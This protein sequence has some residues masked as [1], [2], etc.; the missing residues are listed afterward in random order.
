MDLDRFLERCR[1][2]QWAVADV[3][4]D[5]TPPDLPREQE[6]RVVQLFTD[7]VGV[8]RLAGALFQE[9]ARRT[10]DPVLK[11]VFE[12]FVK[13]EVR[14][15][16]VAQMLADHY[17]VH[18]YRL[19]AMNPHL[20][21]FAPHFV[22][23][24]RYLSTE[25][26][27]IYITTGEL[28]LDV[29]LLRTLNDHVDDA[30]ADRV[31]QLINRDESRHIA[32]DFHMVE[33]YAEHPEPPPHLS[34]REQVAAMW[35]LFQVLRT[36]RPFIREVFFQPMEVM[37]PS[38][39]RMREAFRR[40]QMLATKPAVAARPFPRFLLGLQRAYDTPVVGKLAGRALA[41]L[42]GVDPS[43]LTNLVSPDEADRARR[44][45][46]FDLAREAVSVKSALA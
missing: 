2:D 10:D 33:H 11:G 36:A 27:T 15:A 44:T 1:R 21:R 9:Q 46:M 12:T 24:L 28:I 3:A 32:I 41:R 40:L 17:D 45:S 6:E 31:M 30:M 29:A 7:M 4:F 18:H 5:L 43:V 34:P 38:G 14:H 22:H 19:Y 8:E 13:D 35:A 25:I 39:V 23:A 42:A 20:Q 16:Q 37:D 26:A